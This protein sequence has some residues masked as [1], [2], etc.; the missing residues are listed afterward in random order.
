MTVAALVVSYNRRELLRQCLSALLQQTHP[1]DEIL[2]LDNG[3]T[4]GSVEMVRG[5]FP[6][7]S[8]AQSPSNIG[9]AGGFSAGLDILLSRGHD[10]AWLMD[11]DA[12]PRHDALAPLLAAME[13]AGDT[14][15][16]FVAST[17]L[18]PE[19][20]KLPSHV[21]M[22]IPEGENRLS[23]TP[24]DTYPAAHA[25]FV[26]VLINLQTAR[27]TFLPIADFFIWWDDSE[28]TSRLQVMAGGLA[29]TTSIVVHPDKPEWK[30]LGPRLRYDVRNRLWILRRRDLASSR[31][32]ER[33]AHRFWR[34]TWEQARNAK[35]KDRF[36][37]HLARGL[38]EG[39]LRRPRLTRPGTA[40]QLAVL[41]RSE[42]KLGA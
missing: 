2:V 8:L 38:T 42:P 21:P 24:P 4:D 18:S 33:A 5:E 3:S 23:R 14:K 16:G 34:G 30:D 39:M 26:G 20:K 28:Y 36:A 32:R 1:L 13:A 31:G 11:D 37:W 22:P 25:T 29:S 10:F 27:Q 17:V 35:R 15:P 19:G 9:G 6:S 7:V 41:P 12:V 40:P